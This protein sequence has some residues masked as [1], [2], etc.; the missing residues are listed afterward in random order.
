MIY[1]IFDNMVITVILVFM[2]VWTWGFLGGSF[3]TYLFSETP[4]SVQHLSPIY[5]LNRSLVELSSMGTSDYVWRSLAISGAMTLVCS[6]L[7]VFAATIRKR[8]KRA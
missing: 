1:A 8:G 4:A 3:E 5:Y 2:A 7:A 6:A